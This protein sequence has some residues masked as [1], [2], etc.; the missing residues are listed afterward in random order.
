MDL[1]AQILQKIS[2]F[3]GVHAA[4]VVLV[5]RIESVAG[6]PGRGV[7]PTYTETETEIDAHIAPI[8][9]RLFALI[10]VQELDAD[11]QMLTTTNIVNYE[12]AYIKYDDIYY[13]ILEK[14]TPKTLLYQN[15]YVYALKR[16]KGQFGDNE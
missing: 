2:S 5:T 12:Q 7:R 10:T 14:N 9:V 8:S 11:F 16:R 3:D 6:D 1:L 13:S 15:A 4:R